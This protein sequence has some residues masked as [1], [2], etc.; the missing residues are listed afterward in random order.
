V[1]G[2]LV[3]LGA[4]GTVSPA[5][6]IDIS[7]KNEPIVSQ[8]I[9][10]PT[11]ATCAGTSPGSPS[12][13]TLTITNALDGTHCR[14]TVQVETLGSAA[15]HDSARLEGF[16][17]TDP[18]LSATVAQCG[19]TIAPGIGNATVTFD[20][21]VDTVTPGQTLTFDPQ[22]DGLNWSTAAGYSGASCVQTP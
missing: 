22:T 9:A 20:I 8:K 6:A 1:L 17:V 19:Q 7:Y 12:P 11:A 10:G 13:I 2:Y 16:T 18:N 3:L 4:T 14:F 15:T 21:V 5:K